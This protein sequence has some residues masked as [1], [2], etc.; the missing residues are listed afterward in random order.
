[1][2]KI[3][4]LFVSI[5]MSCLFLFALTGCSRKSE[6]YEGTEVV[7]ITYSTVSYFGG[8]TKDYL[9]DFNSGTAS[10][11][12]YLPY[13]DI[14]NAISEYQQF[15]D[16]TAAAATV[17]FDKCYMYGLFSLEEEYVTEDII[18]DGGGWSLTIEYVDGTTFSSTGDNAGPSDVFEKCKFAFYELCGEGIVGTIPSEFLFPPNISL[19][20]NYQIGNIIYETNALAGIRR[21]D[22]L[23]NGHSVSETSYYNVNRKLSE[24]NEFDSTCQYTLVLYTGNY[25]VSKYC[26]KFN[27]FTLTCYD[28]NEEMSGEQVIF[29]SKWFKQKE[30]PLQLDKIYIYKL[31]WSNRDFVEYTFNTKLHN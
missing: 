7:K 17:F 10:K 31:Y 20:F 28:Y 30:F 9:F 15:A 8:Y 5:I 11:R 12:E 23:W 1:M 22:Y 26:K 25:H 24:S 16:F 13:S 3:F 2:K 6:S 19:S 27:K 4:I 18:C 29:S 21:G 14:D